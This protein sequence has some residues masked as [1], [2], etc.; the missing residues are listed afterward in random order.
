MIAAKH[1]ICACLWL[2]ANL[3]SAQPL[4][5]PTAIEWLLDCPLP[6]AERLD[7][8]V[9]QRTQCGIVSVPRN[10]AAPSKGKLRLYLTRVGSAPGR[11]TAPERYGQT[12]RQQLHQPLGGRFSGV[13]QAATEVHAL[14]GF[15]QRGVAICF[16]AALLC[17][18]AWDWLTIRPSFF[19]VRIVSDGIYKDR[20]G[21]R[22]ARPP[23]SHGL[24]CS[25]GPELH[26]P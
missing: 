22:M 15:G 2:T 10:Y 1:L 9:L 4:I 5:P 21:E 16:R 6:T 25:I 7:P 18:A 8:E 12:G 11:T 19:V 20:T 17:I 26:R 3:A 14:P 24:Q 23:A 13:R